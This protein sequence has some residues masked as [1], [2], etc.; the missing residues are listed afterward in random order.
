MTCHVYL[1]KKEYK[2]KQK[3]LFNW[4]WGQTVKLEP[5]Q[6]STSYVDC[7]RW[8]PLP[9]KENALRFERIME[10]VMWLAA[11]QQ[12]F[13]SMYRLHTRGKWKCRKGNTTPEEVGSHMDLDL[14]MAVW[15]VVFRFVSGPVKVLTMDELYG[16]TFQAWQLASEYKQLKKEPEPM[17]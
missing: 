4:K 6:R 3:R 15:D 11:G 14:V 9:C 8:E 16:L 7:Y 1:V 2:Q 5:R 12:A 17:W 10:E 13:K